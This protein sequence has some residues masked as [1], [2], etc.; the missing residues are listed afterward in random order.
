MKVYNLRGIKEMTRYGPSTIMAPNKKDLSYL[1]MQFKLRSEEEYI[2][3]N[4]RKYYG[5]KEIKQGH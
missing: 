5:I 4:K 2:K 3:Q 1:D